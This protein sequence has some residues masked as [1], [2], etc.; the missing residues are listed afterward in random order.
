[1]EGAMKHTIALLQ[2]LVLAVT[3]TPPVAWA[4]FSGEEILLRYQE[5]EKRHPE[6]E[7]RQFMRPQATERM[8][9][10]KLLALP[11]DRLDQADR[12]FLHSIRPKP[13]WADW[14][15]R[16]VMEIA[17]EHSELMKGQAGTQES[18]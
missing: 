14:E 10:D 7:A 16:A 6:L 9:V 3:L 2:G 18:K 1:M 5:L 15:H 4:Q 12:D 11:S 8:T 17:K 13:L